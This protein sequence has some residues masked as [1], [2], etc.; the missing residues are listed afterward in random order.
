VFISK[1]HNKST[2]FSFKQLAGVYLASQIILPLVSKQLHH[3]PSTPHALVL[4]WW[5][6]LERPTSEI[7]ANST[8]QRGKLE[9]IEPFRAKPAGM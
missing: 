9:P 4:H 2:A 5:V 6:L 7:P 8:T 3:R 1:K